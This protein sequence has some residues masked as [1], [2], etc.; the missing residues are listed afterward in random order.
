M[1]SSTGRTC[2][3]TPGLR[4]CRRRDRL[5]ALRARATKATFRACGRVELIMSGQ[6]E[7]GHGLDEQ[8]RET[9]T[10]GQFMRFVAEREQDDLDL[11][12]VARVDHARR[13]EQ[14]ATLPGGEAAPR[15]DEPDIAV[16]N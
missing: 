5:P 14:G 6:V 13:I 3:R 12:P 2:S 4:W 1:P 16:R 7:A 9:V 15:A 11:P 8:L 10:A